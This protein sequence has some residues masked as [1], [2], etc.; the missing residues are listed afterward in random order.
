MPLYPSFHW[1]IRH[2][3][4]TDTSLH[5][6]CPGR[7]ATVVYRRGNVLYLNDTRMTQYYGAESAKHAQ[8]TYREVLRNRTS[9]TPDWG[10]ALGARKPM[11]FGKSLSE[12]YVAVTCVAGIET[13]FTDYFL[14]PQRKGTKEPGSRAR[15]DSGVNVLVIG[16][17]ST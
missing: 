8:C 17:D 12:E 5:R 7:R 15:K 10:Y 13:L 1:T 3:N 9:S 14:L 11:V 6:R 16:I 2:A 4:W